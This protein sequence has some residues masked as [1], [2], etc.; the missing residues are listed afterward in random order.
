MT[1]QIEGVQFRINYR[2]SNS[3]LF[4]QLEPGAE[5]KAKSGSM[6]AMDATVKIKG[7]LKFSVAKLLSGDKMSESTFTGPGE[8]MIAPS[9]WGDIVPIYLDGHTQWSVGKDAYLACTIGVTHKNKSQGVGKALLSGEFLSAYNV[10][11][12]GIM[13]ITSLGAIYSRTLQP[14][15]QW[16]VDKGHLVAWTATCKDEDIDAGGLFSSMNTDEDSV[17][18]FTGPGIVYIQTRNPETL[19]GWINDRVNPPDV[20][21]KVNRVLVSGS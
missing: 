14:G 21:H 13:W 9:T 5:V 11:G 12:A 19:G 3:M 8:V 4:L 16:I 1:G 6:V 20:Y 2:D 10:I 15:E 17:C 7:K 18:R